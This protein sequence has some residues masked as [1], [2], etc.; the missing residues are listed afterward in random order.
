MKW[1]ADLQEHFGNKQFLQSL[2]AVKS[3]FYEH[4][5]YVPNSPTIG[6]VLLQNLEKISNISFSEND[7]TKP[8]FVYHIAK[9]LKQL[10]AD[11]EIDE[12][13]HEGTSSN[14]AAMDTNDLYVSSVT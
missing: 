3:T 12:K 1:I 8:E 6:P 10:Y 5:I 7:L 11:F 13:Y 9:L 2:T 4:N 14:V